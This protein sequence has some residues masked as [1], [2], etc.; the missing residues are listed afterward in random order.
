MWLNFLGHSFKP[1]FETPKPLFAALCGIIGHGA[2]F[3][4]ICAASAGVLALCMAFARMFGKPLWAGLIAFVFF[5]VAN[6]TVLPDFLLS[7]YWPMPYFFLCLAAAYSFL[8]KKPLL[9]ALL[10]LCAGLMRPEAWTFPVLFLCITMFKKERG[11]SWWFFLPLIA[12]GLWLLFDHRITGSFTYSMDVTKYYAETLG[13]KPVSGTGYWPQVYNSVSSSFFIPIL[14][15]GLIACAYSLIRTRKTEHFLFASLAVIPFAFFWVLSFV[16]PVIVQVRFLAFP[17]L[18]FCL[19][20]AMFIA[21]CSS[22]KPIVM[23]LCGSLLVISFQTDLFTTTIQ[24]IKNDRAIASARTSLLP[25]LREASSTA[26][27]I[28][29]GRSMAYYSYFLGEEA[30]KKIFMIREVVTFPAILKSAKRGLVVFIRRDFAGRDL[31]LSFLWI[32]RL[33]F[34]NGLRF[35]PLQKT[36][37]GDAVV[38]GFEKSA[39]AKAGGQAPT[40]P[41]SATIYFRLGIAMKDK[42][43]PKDALEYFHKSLL[44]NPG[45]ADAHCNIGEI[46]ATMGQLENAILQ[47][48]EAIRIN[49]RCSEAHTTIGVALGDEHKYQEAIVHFNEA[50]RVDP[51]NASAHNNLAKI[52][53]EIGDLDGG[54][55][56]CYEAIRLKP[57]FAEAHNNLGIA[58]AQNGE[59][60]KAIGQLEEALRIQPGFA[61]AKVNLEHARRLL[62]E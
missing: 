12:P 15:L 35:I 25:C 4:V 21:G 19:Y 52:L 58:F 29:C 17:L 38:Y 24:R 20:G 16:D 40:L 32:P 2:L 49:P 13:L 50:I 48:N 53:F 60:K 57:S 22:S 23:T 44:L 1:P 51:H 8:K 14:A 30:S 37:N 28:L 18:I 27:I 59:Y 61:I 39:D 45:N 7:S 42:G 56:H 46:Y 55:S 62:K 5:L 34:A 3:P 54:F 47:C 26:D 9:S 10:L 36:L 33:Y 31:D 41:D 11:F 43:M 6:S